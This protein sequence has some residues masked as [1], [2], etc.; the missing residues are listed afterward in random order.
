[1][2]E[3]KQ[4]KTELQVSVIYLKDD[5]NDINEFDF[6]IRMFP[7]DSKKCISINVVPRFS[8]DDKTVKHIQFSV[9][10]EKDLNA[11][12]IMRI[13]AQLKELEWIV[14]DKDLTAKYAQSYLKELM[15]KQI[16]NYSKD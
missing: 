9:N 2:K 6:F 15:L 5:A 14:C 11:Y 7:V 4:M 16:E 10:T 3:V 13:I 1:M 12:D 8:I